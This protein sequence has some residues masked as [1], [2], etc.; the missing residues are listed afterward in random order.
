[1]DEEPNQGIMVGSKLKNKYLKSKSEID[2]Q[3]Q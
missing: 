3:R 2:K 1:M